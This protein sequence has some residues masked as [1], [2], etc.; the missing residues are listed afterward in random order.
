[1]VMNKNQESL[2]RKAL[3]ITSLAIQGFA[4]LLL[5]R[6]LITLDVPTNILSTALLL[7]V[8]VA[9]VIPTIN[10]IRGKAKSGEFIV[11][12]VLNTIATMVA[13][14]F[15]VYVAALFDALHYNY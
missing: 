4:V 10:V 2:P 7:A 5:G 13:I 1:M 11:A 14:G 6:F 3:W 15:L 9:V 12:L 8:Y